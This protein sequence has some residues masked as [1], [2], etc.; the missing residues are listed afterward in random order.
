VLRTVLALAL[1]A[2]SA[3]AA[4][5]TEYRFGPFRVVSN[6]GDKAAR[7]RLT[8]ME[9]TRFVLGNLLG[10]TDLDT[11]WPMVLV[12]FPNQRDYGPHALPQPFVEGGSA[13]LSAWT[14]DTPPPLDWRRAVTRQLLHDN[15]GRMPEA[16]ETALGDLLS[17]LEVKATRVE[18]GA[19]LPAGVLQGDRLRDWIKLQLLATRP[20]FSGKFRVYLNN[21]QQGGDEQL[22]AHNA[23]DMTVAQLNVR[24]DQYA[25]AGVF[26]AVAVNGRAVAPNKDFY[27]RRLPQSEVDGLL[28]ELQSAGKS[29]PPDSPRGLLAQGT[30]T[31]LELAAK[32][33]P[34][35]GEPHVRLAALAADPGEK[36]KEL[37][38]ATD[39]EP[40]NTAYW[41]A[42]AEAQTAADLPVDAAKSW[43]RAELAAPT[44]AER[45][46]IRQIRLDAEQKRTDFELAERQRLADER[47][48]EL[49]RLK[50]EAAARVHAAEDAANKQLGE[51]KSGATPVPWNELD[52]ANTVTGT[53]TRIECVAGPRKN[54]PLKLIVQQTGGGSAALLI[55]DP[56]AFLDNNPRAYT[57]GAQ[58]PVQKVRIT[59]DGKPDGKLGTAGDIRTIEFPR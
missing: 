17:T 18:L 6:A 31:S 39:L 19:P 4:D 40:R 23:F 27:E 30:L 12:L 29:F 3:S 26:E 15:A 53:L 55:R 34:R 48:R 51:L 58:H 45:A 33:N 43:T 35:W 2:S 38:I 14:A 24:V 8:E 25:R 57:C 50:D 28:A 22:A 37:K 36:V 11:V 32:A 46:R 56:K 41:Q 1:L 49:Q 5:W 54:G 9:Q 16:I 44:A 13:M 10:K 47:A 59:H 20:E 52:G 21:V 7:E 42:L